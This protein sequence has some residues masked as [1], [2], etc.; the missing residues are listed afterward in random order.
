MEAIRSVQASMPPPRD[1]FAAIVRTSSTSSTAQSMFIAHKCF[2]K[3]K[4]AK[5]THQLAHPS[6][7]LSSPTTKSLT[8]SEGQLARRTM[9]GRSYNSL[10]RSH[11]SQY[12]ILNQELEKSVCAMT[13]NSC[14]QL[15]TIIKTST[16]SN[17]T[18]VFLGS[19]T[20]MEQAVSVAP[21][22]HCH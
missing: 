4:D 9:Q 6:H 8:Q 17:E 16:H 22:L 7:C 21:H 14:M 20:G 5:T 2:L 12:F 11:A 18:Q 15:P 1:N 3:W 13:T 10:S 19:D